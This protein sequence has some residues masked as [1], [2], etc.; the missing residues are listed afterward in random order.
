MVSVE[1]LVD[2]V[3]AVDVEAVVKTAKRLFTGLPTFAA[4]GPLG[5]VESFDQ[6][7]TRLG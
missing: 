6:I 7:R 5:Q 4:I 3:E 1:E 2:K